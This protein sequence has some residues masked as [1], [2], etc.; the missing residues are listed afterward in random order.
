MYQ[1]IEQQK[2]SASIL[3]LSFIGALSHKLVRILRRAQCLN[4]P[5][6]YRV[7]G[8][9]SN[10]ADINDLPGNPGGPVKSRLLSVLWWDFFFRKLDKGDQLNKRSVKETI[11][12]FF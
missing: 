2:R 9:T 6:Y 3:L 12:I 5:F 11:L 8:G 10:G 1:S 4:R 7:T